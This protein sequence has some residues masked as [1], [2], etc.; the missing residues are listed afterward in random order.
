MLPYRMYSP[1][2]HVDVYK[3]LSIKDIMLVDEYII[4]K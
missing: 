4:K 3:E 2:P 1:L